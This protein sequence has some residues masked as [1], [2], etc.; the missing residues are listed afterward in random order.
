MRW[1]DCITEFMD[2]SL[3]KLWELMTDRKAWHAEVHAVAEL[4]IT[5][6]LN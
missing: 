1:L 4:N 3:I 2:M 5:M 6:H